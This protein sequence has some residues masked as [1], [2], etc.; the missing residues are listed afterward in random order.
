MWR[1]VLVKRVLEIVAACAPHARRLG[2]LR[3]GRALQRAAGG[4][5]RRHPGGP[6]CAAA[7][8]RP[9]ARRPHGPSGRS[10]RQRC[11]LRVA[12]TSAPTAAS[13]LTAGPATATPAEALRGHAGGKSTGSPPRSTRTSLGSTPCPVCP[14]VPHALLHSPRA[15]LTCARTKRLASRNGGAEP[16][17]APLAPRL[18]LRIR[19]PPRRHPPCFPP[20]RRARRPSSRPPS[21]ARR[22]AA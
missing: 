9:G 15:R 1:F 19:T 4:R 7:R 22:P 18:T 6:A 17:R 20:T 2:R 11:C 21:L 10:N 13:L 12:A 3:E 8:D 5:G 14:L 16:F